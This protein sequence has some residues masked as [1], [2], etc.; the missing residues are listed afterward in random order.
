MNLGTKKARA[1]TNS[2]AYE[3]DLQKGHCDRCLSVDFVATYAI[4]SNNILILIPI[5]T[6]D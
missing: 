1:T 4:T 2:T 3:M 5:F 6:D